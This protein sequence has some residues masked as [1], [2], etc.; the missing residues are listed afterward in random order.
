[1]LIIESADVLIQNQLILTLHQILNH[2]K[3]RPLWCWTPW[4]NSRQTH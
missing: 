3:N 1:M 4:Q 2:A